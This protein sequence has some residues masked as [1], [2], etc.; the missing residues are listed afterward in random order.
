MSG[1]QVAAVEAELEQHL[2]EVKKRLGCSSVSY[3][4]VNKDSHLLDI[5]DVRTRKIC[6]THLLSS[7]TQLLYH[8]TLHDVIAG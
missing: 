4:S 2:R 6:C 8:W 3:V 7:F 5:P 1:A